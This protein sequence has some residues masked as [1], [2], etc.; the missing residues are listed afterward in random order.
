MTIRLIVVVGDSN[1]V[2]FGSNPSTLP[3]QYAGPV[4]NAFEFGQGD[5]YWGGL[6]PGVNTGTPNNPTS[7]GVETVLAHELRA[8]FP[9]DTLLFVTVKQ[10]S[11]PLAEVAGV[12]DW[13]PLSKG[14]MFDITSL[15]IQNARLAFTNATGIPAPEVSMVYFS[16]GPN[17]AADAGRAAAFE[18]NL[19][20]FN[21]AARTFWMNDD[22]GLIVFNRMTDAPSL[23]HNS[24]VRVA[25]WSVDQADPYAVSFKTIGMG[26][27]PDLFHYD[28]AGISSI[29]QTVASIYDGWF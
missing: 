8:D 11:T 24:T 22:E 17:D 3:A 18:A 23:A 13:N 12:M 26:V 6:T 16:N 19:T 25:E 10:G 28:A 5:T 9:D 20:A 2:Y 15:T 27:Q 29:G 21:Q 14:E 1:A 7:W 4:P